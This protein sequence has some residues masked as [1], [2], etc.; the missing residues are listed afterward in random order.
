MMRRRLITIGALGS[1]FMLGSCSKNYGLVLLDLRTSGPLAAPV[2]RIK[3]S[4]KD[5]PARTVTTETIGPDGF[6]VG[7]Y[8]PADGGAVTVTAQALDAV[9]CVLGSG[10]ATVP[11]L[12][13]GA[14]SAP[15]T[16]FIRP[17]PGNGCMVVEPPTDAGS[18][19]GSGDDGGGAPDADADAGVDATDDGV[20]ATDDGV[21]AT[22]DGGEDAT[23][24]DGSVD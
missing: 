3:L 18:D 14:T 13:A 22:D 8:G 17:V 10:S 2:V 6:R 16:L 15:T 11:A 24:T 1:V 7:F 4:A 5:W 12:E 21:D 9:D 20:D 23:P 19:T